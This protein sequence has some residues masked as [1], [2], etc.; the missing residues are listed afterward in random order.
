MATQQQATVYIT[1]NTGGDAQIYL[2]HN[3][4][5]NGTQQG[6]WAATSGQTVGP[7]TA[8]FE[9]GWNAGDALDWWSVLVHVKDGPTPGF[10]VCSGS[11]ISYWQECQFQDSDASQTM[12]FAV[13]TTE[14]NVNLY[15]GP[16]AGGAMTRLAPG[17][18][19]THVFVV[20][21]ENRSFDSMFAMSGIKGITAATTKDF[22]TYKNKTYFVQPSAPLSLPT[23][24][25]HEF[26]DVVEQLGGEGA[27]NKWKPGGPYP[28]IHNSGFVANYATTKDELTGLPPEKDWGDVM[29]CFATPTQLPV[30]YKLATEF[31]ICDQWHS[32]LPGLTWPNRFFLHGASSSGMDANPSSDQIEEWEVDGFVYPN[33]SI[34]DALSNANIPYR[35]YN[36]TTGGHVLGQ[37]LY[38]DHPEKGSAVGAVPQVTSLNG[39]QM[40]D[41]YSLSQ[42]KSDLQGPYPYPYT[43][44]EPHYGNVRDNTY[45]GGSSQHPMDDVYGGEHLLSA[46]YYAIRNSPY[47]NTSLLIITY[48][49]HGGLF[50]KVAPVKATPPG[51]NP[52]PGY[53]VNGFTFNLYGVRVP[54]IVVSPLIPRGTVDNTVYDHSSVLRTLEDLW[55]I[56]PLTDRDG[57][58]KN[59]LKSLSLTTPR[60]DCP[61]SINSPAPSLVNKPPIGAEERARL[62]ALPLP[63]SGNLVNALYTLKKAEVELSSRTPAEMAAIHARFATIKTRGDAEDYAKFVLEKVRVVRERRRLAQ[64]LVPKV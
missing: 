26:L 29:A 30:L 33:G 2:F 64:Q 15:S 63:K 55:G 52:P 4:S 51:D 38:S 44:I 61:T 31:A 45:E 19:I 3:N 11:T 40:A 58:A 24:P 37:S 35:F 32:S 23:D 27:Q 6:S 34:Y 10:Y 59:V 53:N 12:T 41:I 36:D 39:V 46:V 13:S 14:F 49:E 48:D 42:F 20:M 5:T 25:G 54:G 21:L 17:A 56:K 28:P 50:D 9:S 57:A 47:W 43:F 62:D 7:L 22:N 60:T 18:P 8:L 16:C 1:N